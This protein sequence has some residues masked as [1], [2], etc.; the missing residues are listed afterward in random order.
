MLLIRLTTIAV[1]VASLGV[2]GITRFSTLSIPAMTLTPLLTCSLGLGALTL[3]LPPNGT[4][5]RFA[6]A[7]LLAIQLPVL[8]NLLPLLPEVELVPA[9][10]EVPML[11]AGF[12]SLG[13]ARLLHHPDSDAVDRSLVCSML[14]TAIAVLLILALLFHAEPL[15]RVPGGNEDAI[16]IKL[17]ETGLFALLATGQLAL[18]PASPLAGLRGDDAVAHSRRQLLPWIL[19]IPILIGLLLLLGLQRLHLDEATAITLSVMANLLLPLLVLAIAGR[20]LTQMEQRKREELRARERQV[21]RQ[22]QRDEVTRLLNRRGWEEELKEAEKRCRSQ[23]LDA[24]I[25]II[26]LD[27]LKQINDE[28]GHEAGDEFIRR[29]ASALKSAARRKDTLARLGGDEFAYL[30]PGCDEAGAQAL[31]ERLRAALAEVEVPASMGYAL[32]GKGG[33]KAAVGAADKAMYADKRSRSSR[34]KA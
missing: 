13:L 18:H 4:P 27:G 12:F 8:A 20:Q 28:Q 26:D 30:A 3:L 5:G 24:S 16:G 9:W 1:L 34:R 21:R 19:S 10:R 17:L 15:L 23:K 14:A 33:L 32:R 25:V 6:A 22:S 29:A 2:A 11:A 7:C 31:T